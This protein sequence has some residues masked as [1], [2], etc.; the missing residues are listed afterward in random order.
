MPKKISFNILFQTYQ[1]NVYPAMLEYL[2]EDLGVSTDSLTTIGVGYEFVGPSWIFAERDA[3]GEIIGLIRRFDNGKKYTVA[4]SKRGL[5]YAINPNYGKE[6]DRYIPGRHNWVRCSAAL[7]CPICSRK[8]W[9]MVS[10][11]DIDNPPAVLCRP[12]I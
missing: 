5:T 1:Q 7:S 10:A 3:K 2:A 8:K 11:E 6:N 4:G 9:C 12:G